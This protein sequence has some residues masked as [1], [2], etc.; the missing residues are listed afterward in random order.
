V[1]G[2]RTYHGA[3]ALTGV[4][5]CAGVSRTRRIA[6]GRNAGLG[7]EVTGSLGGLGRRHAALACM[8]PSAPP[9]TLSRAGR[10]GWAAD[11]AIQTSRS[12]LT[13][14]LQPRHPSRPG[15]STAVM[16]AG[17]ASAAVDA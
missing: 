11:A 7:D 5:I 12:S 14:D 16:A 9:R 10:G 8:M 13:S 4:E 15:G 6:L 17:P 1:G 3:K 2:S